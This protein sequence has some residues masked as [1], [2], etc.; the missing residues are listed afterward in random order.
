MLKVWMCLFLCLEITNSRS[1]VSMPSPDNQDNSDAV[2]DVVNYETVSWDDN[3]ANL[4]VVPLEEIEGYGHGDYS[5]EPAR[6]AVQDSL[7]SKT[8]SWDDNEADI[9][10]VNPEEIEGNEHGHEHITTRDPISEAEKI[11]EKQKIFMKEK[12]KE[13]EKQFEALP[14]EEKERLKA[15]EEK[16]QLKM[17]A[18]MKRMNEKMRYIKEQFNKLPEEEQRRLR[19]EADRLSIMSYGGIN[20]VPQPSDFGPDVDPEDLEDSEVPPPEDSGAS[21]DFGASGSTGTEGLDSFRPE[22]FYP[23]PQFL[24]SP[25]PVFDHRYGPFL[26]FPYPQMELPSNGPA[27]QAHNSYASSYMKKLFRK[28][29]G[30]FKRRRRGAGI[31]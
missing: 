21:S 3:E 5:R 1:F 19:E 29:Q 22:M 23:P 16:L 24:Y 28:R 15:K 26:P 12:M 4:K 31:Q 8:V 18:K 10:V 13:L 6:E 17:K 7:S 9:E 27:M 25:W 11:K 30:I 14:E 20:M 2:K